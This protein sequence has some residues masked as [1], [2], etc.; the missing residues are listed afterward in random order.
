MPWFWLVYVYFTFLECLARMLWRAEARDKVQIN[1]Q[2]EP[3]YLESVMKAF[4]K[5]HNLGTLLQGIYF[6]KVFG[7]GW[8]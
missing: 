5:K 7:C 8:N 2:P 4:G 6:R 1:I 3:L